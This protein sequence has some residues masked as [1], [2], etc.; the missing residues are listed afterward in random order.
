[1]GEHKRNSSFKSLLSLAAGLES[2]VTVYL[3]VSGDLDD[4]GLILETVKEGMV[5]ALDDAGGPL[6]GDGS[7]YSGESSMIGMLSVDFLA[8]RKVDVDGPSTITFWIQ[9]FCQLR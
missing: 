3:G 5:G 7:G 1:M 8:P 9:K 6:G 2:S 4:D